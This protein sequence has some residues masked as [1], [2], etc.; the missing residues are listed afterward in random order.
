MF[1]ARVLEYDVWGNEEGGF[2]VNNVFEIAKIKLN[3]KYQDLEDWQI[4]KR[5]NNKLGFKPFFG[6]APF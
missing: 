5:L 4:L 6:P 1:I 2:D 3:G